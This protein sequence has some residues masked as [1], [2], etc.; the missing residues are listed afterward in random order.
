MTCT[1]DETK[2]LATDLVSAIDDYMRESREAINYL[3]SMIG[4]GIVVPDYNAVNMA[5]GETTLA[6]DTDL[7]DGGYEVVGLTADAAVNLTTITG[8]TAGQIKM[9]IALDDDITLV[10]GATATTGGVLYLNSPV[11]VDLAMSTR[12]VVIL[13]NIGG[14][15][16]AS[17]GYWLEVDRKLQV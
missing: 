5:A 14:D 11:G 13:V 15:G 4:S 3:C 1:V 10:Q 6:I 7:A 12:D 2:P 16:A 17:D 9:I 8:G